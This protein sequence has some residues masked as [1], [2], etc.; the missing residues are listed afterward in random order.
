MTRESILLVGAGAHAKACIDVVEQDGRFAVEGLVGLPS[1]LNS[2]VLG[3]SVCGADADLLNLL[4]CCTNALIAIGQIKTPES[5][6]RLFNL[7]Q[8][9]GYTLPVVVSPHAYVSPRAKLGKGT[10]VIH[11]AVVNA[12]A[13]VGDNCIINSQSLVEHDVVIEDHCHIATAATINGGARIGMGTFIGSNSSVRQGID[14]GER[15]CIGMGQQV[16]ADCKPG[17]CMP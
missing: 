8:K 17:V 4:N 12:G 15:C 16:L 14:I 2:L 9:I 5:R 1:E 10:I 7:L 11:G 3:Y 13:V 6:M